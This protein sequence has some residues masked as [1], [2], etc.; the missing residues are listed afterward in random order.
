MRYTSSVQT[1][2]FHLQFLLLPYSLGICI[3]A[4]PFLFP[5]SFVYIF[6]LFSSHPSSFPSFSFSS[7]SP[8]SPRLSLLLSPESSSVYKHCQVSLI[9]KITTATTTTSN[10]LGSAYYFNYHALYRN[11]SK[12]YFLS[13]PL[14]FNPVQSDFHFEPST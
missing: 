10:F 12:L 8:L 2:F 5:V 4:D 7:Y 3:I 14:L 1:Q 13:S 6:I 9:F 11:I